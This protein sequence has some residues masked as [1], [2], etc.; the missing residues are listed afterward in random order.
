MSCWRNCSSAATELKSRGT[1][2]RK[3]VIVIT[4]GRVTAGSEH[5]FAETRDTL[6]KDSIQFYGIS[7]DI[8]QPVMNRTFSVLDS[9][10]TPTGGDVYF[11]ASRFDI[12]DGFN[13]IVDQARNEYI[14]HYVSTN[15]PPKGLPIFR[16]I[17]VKADPKMKVAH[18]DGYF[19][20]P[21][22]QIR[23]KNSLEGT[24]PGNRMR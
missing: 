15:Q 22:P 24:C 4:D 14:L 12:E 10:A 13:H 3:I 8:S 18:R 11:E 7:T 1:D 2:R 16:R 21:Q 17:T 9:Y 19:Q 6:L 23:T 5:S 20:L